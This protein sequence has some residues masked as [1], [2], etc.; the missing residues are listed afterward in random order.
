MAETMYEHSAEFDGRK[1]TGRRAQIIDVSTALFRDGGY[2][3][4]SVE[5]IADRIGFTKPAIYYYF[6]AKEDILF[7]I[8]DEIVERALERMKAIAETD[9][10]PAAKMHNL[11][12]EN[13]RVILQNINANTVFYNERGLLSV[14]R[15]QAIRE[16]ERQ[17]TGLVRQIYVDGVQAG[18]FFDVNPAVATNTLLGASIWTY[19]WFDPAGPLSIDDVA[20]QIATFVLRGFRRTLVSHWSVGSDNADT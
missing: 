8:V 19:R 16:R 7:A 6:K 3:H 14:E 11:L 4:T 20:E 1:R 5:D 13:T 12:A 10:S 9:Q 15:E 17:Y 18:E 2:Q